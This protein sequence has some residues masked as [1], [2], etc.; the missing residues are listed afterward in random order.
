MRAVGEVGQAIKVHEQG[1]LVSHD[2]VD[3]H[4]ICV[5]VLGLHAL[6][7]IVACSDITT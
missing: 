1:S 2:I 3:G 4:Q 7:A 6:H 5:D